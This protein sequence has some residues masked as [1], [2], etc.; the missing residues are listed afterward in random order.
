MQ[1]LSSSEDAFKQHGLNI[2]ISDM[3]ISMLNINMTL[4]RVHIMLAETEK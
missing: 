4:R 3:Y 1:I 2:E